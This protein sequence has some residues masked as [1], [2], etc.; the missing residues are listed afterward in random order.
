MV[1]ILE[2]RSLTFAET[3]PLTTFLQLL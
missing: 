2:G 1:S 3:V